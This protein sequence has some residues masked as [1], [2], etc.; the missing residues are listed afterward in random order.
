ME[1]VVVET[2]RVGVRYFCIKRER[3]RETYREIHRCRYV[4]VCLYLVENYNIKM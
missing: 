4:I 2:E 1:V 3:E